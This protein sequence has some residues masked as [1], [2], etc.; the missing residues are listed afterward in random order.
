MRVRAHCRVAGIVGLALAGTACARDVIHA[1]YGIPDGYVKTTFSLFGQSVS[2]VAT[3]IRG[4]RIDS[5]GPGVDIAI[6]ADFPAY[7]VELGE[8][9]L[10]GVLPEYGPG[11]GHQVSPLLGAKTSS[12]G[13]LFDPSRTDRMERLWG[14][15]Q[16]S[17]V[18]VTDHAAFQIAVW[19]I[20]FD[21]DMDAFNKTGTMYGAVDAARLQ[22]QG[23]L[24][25]IA[26]G[27]GSAQPLE[28]LSDP[29]VQDLI[30][31]APTPG[32]VLLLGAGALVLARRRRP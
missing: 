4:H 10:A 27:G 22:A 1:V 30:T 13:V 28:L 16:S 20:A 9:V 6:A 24:S 8:S 32:T 5:A 11:R 15:F 23:F 7:C 26:G 3:L 12:G 31:A 18:S 19:E 21:H 2:P 17:M 29:G 14:T 25:F